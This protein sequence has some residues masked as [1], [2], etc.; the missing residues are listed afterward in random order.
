MEKNEILRNI[1]SVDKILALFASR[2]ELGNYGLTRL[3]EASRKTLKNFRTQITNEKLTSA[4]TLDEISEQV[5]ALIETQNEGSL[6]S[7]VNLTGT[8]LH[9]NLG[10]ATLPPFVA[11]ELSGIASGNN[12]L[13]YELEEGSR[14][15]RDTHVERILTELTGAEAATVVNNNAAA[16]LLCLNTFASRKEVC[17]SRGELVEIGGSFRI[18]EIM[19]KSGSILREVGTT[20]RTHLKDYA[21]AANERTG[22]IM[23]TH[24]SNYVIQGFTHEASHSELANLGKSRGIPLFA[25]LGSGTLLNLEEFGLNHET[26]VQELITAGTDLVSFSGDKLLGGP[27]AGIIVGRKDL[28][29][30]LK[31]NPL[32]RALRVDKLTISALSG[33]LKLYR[34]PETLTE[35][36]PTMRFLTRTPDEIFKIAQDILPALLKR[37]APKFK[38][39]IIE[40]KSQIGSG[41][42]PLDQLDSFALS[43]E[44]TDNSDRALREIAHKFRQLPV[45]IIGR[46]AGGRLLFDLRTLELP[47]SFL[48]PITELKS[49]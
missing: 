24:T 46:I 18:P 36:L 48:E 43:I 28:I 12:N 19:E 15:D 39:Q 4:P 3:T 34:H 33:V 10:R 40:T 22:L 32:K 26:T 29:S 47:S 45:P 38:V 13:E 23:K 16:V 2:E 25:D 30:Q 7:V 49:V 21:S 37:I 6:K 5:I 11:K 27:Q 9:T 44:S 8:V 20:N 42:L 1:P 41:A 14:G 17:V 31:E 35:N